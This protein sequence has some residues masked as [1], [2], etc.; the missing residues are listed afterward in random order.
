M[1]DQL[2]AQALDGLPPAA[3]RVGYGQYASNPAPTNA[4][5]PATSGYAS[6][7]YDQGGYTVT[8]V[9]DTTP[10]YVQSGSPYTYDYVYPPYATAAYPYDY[11]YYGSP[12]W[13][14]GFIVIDGSG[15][16]HHHWSGGH[17]SGGVGVSGGTGL[18]F[19]GGATFGRGFSA[20]AT[21]PSTGFAVRTP[22]GFTFQNTFGGFRNFGGGGARSFGGGGHR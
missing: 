17:G 5:T 14:G 4:E 22:G 1:E 12:F 15:E 6:Q 2:A 18:T 20:G 19:G 7:P 9:P 13:G 3:V 21:T 16:H 10:S 8:S 11:D